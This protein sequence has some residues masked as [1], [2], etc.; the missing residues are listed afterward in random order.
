MCPRSRIQKAEYLGTGSCICTQ[1]FCNHYQGEE[2]REGALGP[3]QKGLC[4]GERKGIGK[5]RE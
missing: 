3:D 1:G 5:S 4:G 2:V